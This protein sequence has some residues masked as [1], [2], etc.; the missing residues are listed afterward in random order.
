MLSIEA[1][2][3]SETG[4]FYQEYAYRNRLGMACQA[5]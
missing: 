2:G 4:T 1:I 5:N 3:L